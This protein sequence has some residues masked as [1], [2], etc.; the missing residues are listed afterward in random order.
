MKVQVQELVNVLPA[1][2]TDDVLLVGI[3]GCGGAGKSTLAEELA[4]EQENTQVVHIDD[5]YEPKDERVKVTENT[6]VHINFE[7]ERLKQQVLELLEHGEPATYQT[8]AG[9]TRHVE[10]G[11]YIIVEGLGTLGTELRNHFGFKVWIDAS[12]AVRRQG[13]AERDSEDW[14]NIW[15][16]EYL[17]QDARYVQEQAPQQAADI[18][19]NND[20]A[21]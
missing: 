18:V 4:A 12:E 3:D 8:T 20:S 17:P 6:H 21:N 1:L 14:T 11:G 13:G 19:I 10:P 2:G 16:T 9:A 5:F 7:F 15:D